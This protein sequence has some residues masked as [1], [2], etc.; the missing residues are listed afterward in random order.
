VP[1][2]QHEPVVVGVLRVPGVVPHLG[3]EERRH[4]FRA[5]AHEVGWPLPASLVERTESMRRRVAT[6]LSAATRDELW[7][8]IRL[9]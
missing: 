8:G 4:D 2:R 3:K 6:F 1:L 9:A 5:E 7:T